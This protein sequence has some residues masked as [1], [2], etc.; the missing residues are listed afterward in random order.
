MNPQ[1][2]A[3]TITI[4]TITSTQY[5]APLPGGNYTMYWKVAAGIATGYGPDSAARSFQVSAPSTPSVTGVVIDSPP[6]HYAARVNSPLAAT[7]HFTGDYT[8]QIL[9][10]W[11]LDGT[12]TDFQ[13][14]RD[15]TGI[16]TVTLRLPTDAT[17]AVHSL[18]IFVDSPVQR[19]SQGIS[20]SVQQLAQSPATHIL[21]RADSADLSPDGTSSATLT[22]SVLNDGG[23]VVAEAFRTISF[24]ITAGQT[25]ARLAQNPVPATAGLATTTISAGHLSGVVTV[26]ATSPG[27]AGGTATLLIGGQYAHDLTAQY[28]ESLKN[29]RLP[30]EGNSGGWPAVSYST[31][32]ADAFLNGYR[33]ADTADFEAMRRLM[34]AEE[35]LYQSFGS[36]APAAALD[37]DLRSPGASQLLADAADSV[38]Q[39]AGIAVGAAILSDRVS[40]SL[41]NLPIVGGLFSSAAEGMAKY[42]QDLI[43]GTVDL[44]GWAIPDD[45]LRGLNR[46]AFQAAKDN[47]ILPS[48]LPGTSHALEEVLRQSA[49]KAMQEAGTTW[50][51]KRTQSTQDA[52]GCS[53]QQHIGTSIPFLTVKKNVTDGLTDTFLT[54]S[55]DH[56]YSSAFL[57]VGDRYD[58]IFDLISAASGVTGGLGGYGT[59]SAV[60]FK[61]AAL[62]S[63]GYAAYR[64]MAGVLKITTGVP[65]RVAV[66]FGGTT[67]TCQG[68]VGQTEASG[69]GT[70]G[71]SQSGVAVITRTATA[72]SSYAGAPKG[73]GFVG[74][75]NDTSAAIALY[76]SLV[77]RAAVAVGNSDL[78]GLADIDGQLASADRA[79]SDATRTSLATIGASAPFSDTHTASFSETRAEAVGLA[80]NAT[81]LRAGFLLLLATHQASPGSATRQQVL[82]TAIQVVAAHDQLLA[83]VQN[84]AL[85]SWNDSSAASLCVIA[86]HIPSNIAVN[87]PFQVKVTLLNTG[88][89]TVQ[90][91][92]V[93]LE[94]PS[95]YTVQN[96]AAQVVGPLA[97]G[98]QRAATWT[99]VLKTML[100]P[101]PALLLVSPKATDAVVCSQWLVTSIASPSRR[102][103]V[104]PR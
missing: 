74:S 22:A 28:L 102:R 4:P 104:G 51:V 1:F 31:S 58:T 30:S 100:P 9:G 84:A 6:D 23:D 39:T 29:L 103:A 46:V 96:G 32:T 18:L 35:V 98:E 91:G 92:T 48:A 2:D 90:D 75:L 20:Y 95:D 45:E 13:L 86:S 53:A 94:A 89:I 56:E 5:S 79:V 27:L 42:A 97:P 59:V 101:G 61:V 21:L 88:S 73:V 3:N 85:L 16:N 60:V 33:N 87:V 40:S 67:H 69:V 80:S 71:G 77:R 65:S 66:A 19:Q 57:T 26:T 11:S 44:V 37:T 64:S 34:L 38:A 7:A 43:S 81:A 78:A 50:Y 93:S 62:G 41:G 8:G 49:A 12:R 25:L 63:S 76:E 68:A 17:T 70:G 15:P 10:H 99:V 47:L 83:S 52:A 82:D 36:G 14:M 55:A 54:S 72:P 24:Q